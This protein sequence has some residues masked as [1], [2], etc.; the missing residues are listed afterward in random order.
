MK[1]EI[2]KLA[3]GSYFYFRID[4]LYYLFQLLES[5]ADQMLVQR[6]WST[7]NIPSMEKL[8]Q[9]DVKSACSEFDEEFDELIY[10]GKKEITENQ[11]QEIAQFLKI[12]TAKIARD[13]GF[14]TLKKQAVEAFE[15]EEYQEAVRLFSLAAPYSKYDI[16]IYEKRGLC[17]LKLG[18]YSDALAD[19]DYYLISD[20][21]NELVSEAAKMAKK[22]RDKRVK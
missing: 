22:E 10:L 2:E 5:S 15:K 1:S 3:P 17:Y 13:S 12:K 6:F 19:F 20:P 9:F 8:H 4:S 11:Q 18:Q 16:E 14:L 21:E 7:T